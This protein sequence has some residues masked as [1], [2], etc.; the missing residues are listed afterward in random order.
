MIRCYNLKINEISK[1]RSAIMEATILDFDETSFEETVIQGDGLV[2]V[3]FWAP[4]CGPCKQLEPVVRDIAAMFSDRL[5]VG[6]V[7]IDVTPSLAQKFGV[8]GI[9]S[10]LLFQKGELV[11]TQVGLV[12][13]EKLREFVLQAA[14]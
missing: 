13:K 6:K 3:D 7:N 9:P 14:T 5:T 10:L 11:G 4:W 12:T 8:R 1:A 2:L